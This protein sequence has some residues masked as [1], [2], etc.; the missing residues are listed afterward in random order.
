M[1][2]LVDLQGQGN[3]DYSYPKKGKYHE[4]IAKQR[5]G[6]VCSIAAECL[7]DCNSVN[8]ADRFRDEVNKLEKTVTLR[9]HARLGALR[10]A[11][12]NWE[13][14]RLVPIPEI[15]RAYVNWD[16]RFNDFLSSSSAT[17]V[18]RTEKLLENMDISTEPVVP[19]AATTMFG[20][21]PKDADDQ[22]SAST[23]ASTSGDDVL[24]R[25]ATSSES[26]DAMSCNAW[27]ES[28]AV[29]TPL[30]PIKMSILR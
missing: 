20:T 5:L 7:R 4:S 8:F 9:G 23:S 17:L 27:N 14:G 21:D 24:V 2:R 28:N 30:C 16:G 12:F 1:P 29:Q 15:L 10:D 13:G 3:M 19:V 6:I 25:V 22:P 18:E 26:L 11:P